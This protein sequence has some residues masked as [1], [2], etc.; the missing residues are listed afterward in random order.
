[1][2]K[3]CPR[4]DVKRYP[5]CVIDNRKVFCTPGPW[6]KYFEREFCCSINYIY[7][8]FFYKKKI[9]K[10]L[11]KILKTSYANNSFSC[12]YRYSN[13]LGIIK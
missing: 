5:W 12:W 9:S 8:T 4:Q 10:K 1:M 11:Y 13:F 2:L 3:A 7:L 6:T